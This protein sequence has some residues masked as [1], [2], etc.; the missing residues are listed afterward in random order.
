MRCKGVEFT[1]IIE[2]WQVETQ[3][4][5]KDDVSGKFFQCGARNPTKSDVRKRIHWVIKEFRVRLPASGPA[6]CQGPFCI[7]PLCFSLSE[8]PTPH[9]VW[10]RKLIWLIRCSRPLTLCQSFHLRGHWHF[11]SLIPCKSHERFWLVQLRSL[12]YHFDMS[13]YHAVLDLALVTCPVLW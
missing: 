4:R 7:S 9:T 5:K 10:A 12:A 11:P 2:G 8:V 3:R 6:G 13:C 1:W